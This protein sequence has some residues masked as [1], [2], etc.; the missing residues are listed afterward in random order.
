MIVGAFDHLEIWDL[1]SW[2]KYIS[3]ADDVFEDELENVLKA[4]GID[5]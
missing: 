4:R 2:N 1:E 5:L 3:E